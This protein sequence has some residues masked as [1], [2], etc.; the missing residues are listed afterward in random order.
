MQVLK[1][2]GLQVADAA[3]EANTMSALACLE[4][5]QQLKCTCSRHLPVE[6]VVMLTTLTKL[7][8]LEVDMEGFGHAPLMPE[9][10]GVLSGG[11]GYR[12]RVRAGFA[13]LG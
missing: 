9:V 2:E 8:C 4:N 12:G 10:R 6:A 13:G 3:S 1:V 11:K 5:V 7:T